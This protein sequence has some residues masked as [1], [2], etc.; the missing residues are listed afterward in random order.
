MSLLSVG[1][2]VRDQIAIGIVVIVAF[3]DTEFLVSVEV[4]TIEVTRC[5]ESLSVTWT[6][7]KW[8]SNLLTATGAAIDRRC[9]I[10]ITV[11]LAIA[12]RAVRTATASWSTMYHNCVMRQNLIAQIVVEIASVPIGASRQLARCGNSMSSVRQPP[13]NAVVTAFDVAS[14][15]VAHKR[16]FS[17]IRN[18]AGLFQNANI[19]IY[20]NNR[21]LCQAILR[22]SPLTP[23][24]CIC[25]NINHPTLRLSF[26]PYYIKNNWLG[27][28]SK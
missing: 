28:F 16:P 15:W 24:C 19:Y 12:K 1:I 22:K 10:A 11:H 8:R 20:I 4:D 18:S 17:S 5:N 3:F 9:P 26:H 2:T 6:N 7:S 23:P 13:E 25:I 21:T 14:L 27:W